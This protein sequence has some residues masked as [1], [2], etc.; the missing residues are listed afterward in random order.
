MLGLFLL[1]ALNYLFSA[2]FSKKNCTALNQ[3]KWRTFFMY[4]INKISSMYRKI[5]NIIG[6][7]FLLKGIM[8]ENITRGKQ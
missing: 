1:F 4:I 8:R 3:S 6:N 5:M 7:K 2:L